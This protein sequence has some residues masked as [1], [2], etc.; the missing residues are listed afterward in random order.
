M[1]E[2]MLC[3]SID[4]EDTTYIGTD[5]S[6]IYKCF[7]QYSTKIWKNLRGNTSIL[8]IAIS[9]DVKKDKVIRVWNNPS[10]KDDELTIIGEMLGHTDGIHLLVL[11]K[12]N[13]NLLISGGLDNRIG[14]WN[15]KELKLIKTISHRTFR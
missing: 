3:I 1:N 9:K 6:S 2:R 8:S 7:D 14:V 15:I 12:S 4:Q 5:Q 13:Q 10:E 11:M